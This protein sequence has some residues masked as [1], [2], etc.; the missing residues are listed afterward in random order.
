MERF[1]QITA[2]ILIGVA[3]FFWWRGN[4]DGLFI[5]A[6]FGAVSF[7]LSVRFQVKGRLNA[8]ETDREEEEEKRRKGEEEILESSAGLNEM[9]ANQQ[10]INEQ[11]TTDKE[12]I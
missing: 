7:F 8:R 4:A 2:V 5:A 9:S 3:A 12:K 6:V 11:R 1:F 10:M